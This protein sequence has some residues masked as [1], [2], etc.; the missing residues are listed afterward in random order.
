MIYLVKLEG[1][2]RNAST[3][4]AGLV[5]SNSP[6]INDVPLYY[7]AKSP[8]P[9]S[10]FSMKYLEN[11]GLI[12]FD[13]LGLETLSVLDATLKLIKKRDISIN[14]DDINFNDEKTY[15]TL[16]LGNTLGVFQL[17]SIPMRQVLKQLKPDRIEDIIAVVG[18]I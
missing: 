14:L 15:A 11:I 1:L 2:N 17:E 4:A 10:Q 6:I 18:I 16:S 12:K 8:I 13:F 3:H 5:I 9:V 7:D